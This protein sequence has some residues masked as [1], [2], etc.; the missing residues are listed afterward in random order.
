VPAFQLHCVPR[1]QQFCLSQI[2]L[3]ASCWVK[4]KWFLCL[5]LYQWVPICVSLVTSFHVQFRRYSFKFKPPETTHRWWCWLILEPHPDGDVSECDQSDADIWQVRT[6][7][8]I[9]R[10]GVQVRLKDQ[11]DE[12]GAQDKNKDKDAEIDKCTSTCISMYFSM[13]KTDTCNR[14]QDS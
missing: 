1:K 14:C 11:L 6:V 12:V 8:Y 3:K 4:R 13:E 9:P 2:L 5:L 10:K 7:N